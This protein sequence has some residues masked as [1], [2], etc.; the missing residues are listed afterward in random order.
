MTGKPA[1]RDIVKRSLERLGLNE[2]AVRQRILTRIRDLFLEHGTRMQ[3]MEVLDREF[4]RPR[5]RWRHD[6]LY[7]AVQRLQQGMPGIEPLPAEILK[8]PDMT[9]VKARIRVL[10]KAGKKWREIADAL[11]AG[12]LRPA[13]A[14]KFTLFQVMDLVRPRTGRTRTRRDTSDA[15]NR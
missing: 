13:R 10:R 2:K 15:R 5:G 7:T 9:G 12:G 3:I 1:S 8:R 6:H 14:A 11:N 4:P